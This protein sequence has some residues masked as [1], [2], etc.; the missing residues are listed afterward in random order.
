M[1]RCEDIQGELEAFLS[2]EVDEPKRSE[3]QRHLDKCQNCSV[4]LRQLTSLSKVL[5]TWKEIEPSPMMYEK[6]KTRMKANKSSCGRAFSYSFV[7]KA[8]L[9]FVEVAAIVVLTLLISHMFQKPAPKENPLA[10]F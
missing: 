8:A 3:I 5:Q 2:D 1:M 10:R 6:L 4:V 7:K 9:R